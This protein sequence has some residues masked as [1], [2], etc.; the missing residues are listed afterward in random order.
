M[1]I[2]VCYILDSIMDNG[3]KGIK[4]T[5]F[6][7]HFPREN[8]IRDEKNIKKKERNRSCKRNLR[9]TIIHNIYIFILHLLI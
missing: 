3:A 7:S 9:E 5:A 1:H 8:E 4:D 2:Y 6:F